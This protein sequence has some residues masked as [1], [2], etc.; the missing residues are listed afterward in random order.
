MPSAVTPLPA[1]VVGTVCSVPLVPPGAGEVAVAAVSGTVCSV[2]LVA[3]GAAVEVAAVSAVFSVVLAL[4]SSLPHAAAASTRATSAVP[5]ANRLT[6]VICA[7]SGLGEVSAALAG[8]PVQDD[9]LEPADQQDRRSTDHRQHVDRG[10][11]LQWQVV[12]LGHL[13][14]VAEAT[15][16][17]GEEL[18]EHGTEQRQADGD[19]SG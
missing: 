19:T 4:L 6:V 8:V 1:P 3:P 14:G 15:A 13:D 2:P 10:P 11:Q 5:P 18:A 7:P 12:V 17:P 16:D 9:P